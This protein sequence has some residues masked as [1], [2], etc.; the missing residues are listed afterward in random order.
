VPRNLPAAPDDA[1]QGH[2]GDGFHGRAPVVVDGE[3]SFTDA[4]G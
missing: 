4:A 1:V 3:K 2:G